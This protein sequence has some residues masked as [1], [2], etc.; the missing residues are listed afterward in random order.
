MATARDIQRWKRRGTTTQR[1]LGSDHRKTKA[2]LMPAALGQP[3]PI[4]GPRCDR[5]MTD[6]RR[7][8]LDHSVP[9]ILG[10]TRGDRI[11]CMPC[12]TGLGAALGNRLRA[13]RR[14][15]QRPRPM[16]TRAW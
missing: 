4:Q 9:R 11:V 7:M 2:R 14:A 5:I 12:N 8:Q 6:P 13:G 3:C 15:R 16:I 10:G 1:G